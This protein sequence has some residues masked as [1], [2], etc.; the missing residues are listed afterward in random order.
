MCSRGSDQAVFFCGIIIINVGVPAP[1]LFSP[2]LCPLRHQGAAMILKL[3]LVRD[4]VC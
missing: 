1:P 3:A 2:A 4:Q